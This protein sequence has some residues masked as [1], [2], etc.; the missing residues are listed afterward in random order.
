MRIEAFLNESPIFAVARTAR[1]LEAMAAGL[2]AAEELNFFEGMLL[3]ALFFEAPHAVKPSQL[4][5]SFVTTRGNVSHA[6]SALEARALVQRKIDPDDARAY[7]I[8]LRPAGR[9]MAVRV[10]AAFDQLQKDFERSLG[11]NVLRETIARLN[12]LQQMPAALQHPR[13]SRP[14]ARQ[15]CEG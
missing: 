13:G 9:R 15:R 5:T 4:A 14:A 6:L 12:H 11:K 10:I 3:A 8:S 2:L 1:R 7:L